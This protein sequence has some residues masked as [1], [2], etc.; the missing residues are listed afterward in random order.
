MASGKSCD[1]HGVTGFNIQCVVI[2]DIRIVGRNLIK[3][4]TKYST[5]SNNVLTWETTD[6]EFAGGGTGASVCLTLGLAYGHISTFHVIL[7]QLHDHIWHLCKS[8]LYDTT[9]IMFGYNLALLLPWPLVVVSS[10]K[11]QYRP[12]NVASA[13][14]FF[15]NHNGEQMYASNQRCYWNI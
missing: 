6:K 2:K 9:N 8:S 14:P 7:R 12:T 15:C 5:W 11:I 10:I 4:L 13:A 1:C 3:K